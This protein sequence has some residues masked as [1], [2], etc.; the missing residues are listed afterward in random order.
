MLKSNTVHRF[1]FRRPDGSMKPIYFDNNATTPV[2]A[3]VFEAMRPFLS[4]D[5]SYG[6]PS[7]LH[8]A[9]QR[10]H[11]AL[12]SAREKVA[13]LLGA[14]DPDEIVFTSSGTEADNAAVIGAAFAHRDAGRHLVTSAIE[15]HAVLHACCGR[16]PQDR[17]PTAI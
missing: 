8:T 2:R 4:S 16:T 11:A 15:H 9:G 10:A 6:N 7:S 17:V 5:G 12:E 3:E 14:A 1:Y 13:A